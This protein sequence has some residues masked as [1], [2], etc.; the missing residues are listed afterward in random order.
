MSVTIYWACLEDE[1]VK[2]EEPESV[3]KRFYNLGIRHKDSSSRFG[4]NHCPVFN[5]SLKNIYAVKSIYDYS[6]KIVD[7]QC[8]SLYYDQKFFDDHVFIRS[9]E[10]KFF[11]FNVKYIFFTDQDSLEI[12]A[13]QHPVF[14]ENEI[15]K[16]CMIIPG[17][18]DI[19][20]YFRNLEFAFILKKE[21][22]EFVV[23]DEDV[24]YYLKFHTKEKINFKQFKMT[25]ELGN[26][27]EDN[28]RANN[29]SKLNKYTSMDIWYNKFKGKQ[30]ILNK[31]R[32][33]LID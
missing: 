12:S 21:F 4:I 14:E 8:Q 10:K 11:S 17:G 22:E 1:W 25:Q 19:G 32:E 5:E 15:T 29:Y 2:A 18:F 7:N 9:I 26:I 30:Y 13:Y 3:S 24:L 20:K 23:E 16:R 27:M 6:F 31:I 33:N 28:R